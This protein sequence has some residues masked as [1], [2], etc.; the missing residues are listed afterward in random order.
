MFTGWHEERDERGSVRNVRPSLP[1]PFT[2][3]A[4]GA[5]WLAGLLALVSMMWQ[6]TASM[7]AATTAQDMAYGA[8]KSQVGTKSMTLGWIGV[9]LLAIS[10]IGFISMSMSIS[11][12]GR[13]TD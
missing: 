9:A 3:I 12:L 8:A 13:L 6:H 2:Q 4:V 7:A 1:R 5:T 11:L 10:N